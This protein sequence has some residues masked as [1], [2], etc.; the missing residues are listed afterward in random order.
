MGREHRKPQLAMKLLNLNT[1][2]KG[3]CLAGSGAGEHCS[4][5]VRWT[6]WGDHITLLFKSIPVQVFRTFLPTAILTWLGGCWVFL[7]LL[8]LTW[9]PMFW[10]LTS[11]ENS[12]FCCVLL[13]FCNAAWAQESID[14]AG[15]SSVPFRSHTGDVSCYRKGRDHWSLFPCKMQTDV[16]AFALWWQFPQMQHLTCAYYKVNKEILHSNLQL[17]SWSQSWHRWDTLLCIN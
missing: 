3:L 17:Y 6:V 13:G 9:H 16:F 7:H 14:W 8:S 10:D 11:S 12:C 4:C 5:F 2:H 1:L 15:G